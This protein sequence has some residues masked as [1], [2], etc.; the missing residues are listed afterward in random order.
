MMRLSRAP[1]FLGFEGPVSLPPDKPTTGESGLSSAVLGALRCARVPMTL[2]QIEARIREDVRVGPQPA[3]LRRAIRSLRA[4]GQVARISPLRAYVAVT[5]GAKRSGSFL[6][7]D[8]TRA[9]LQEGAQ[10]GRSTPASGRFGNL[11]VI[12]Y[13]FFLGRPPVQRRRIR[14]VFNVNPAKT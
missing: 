14:E 1:I 3:A 13:H 11:S 10:S 8:R 4:S 7:T 9:L 2:P 6:C 12:V 5:S